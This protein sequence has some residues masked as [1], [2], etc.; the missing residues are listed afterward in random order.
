MTMQMKLIGSFTILIGFMLF[1]AMTGLSRLGATQNRLRTIVDVSS[2]GGLLAAQIQQDMLRLQSQQ[3]A[4]ALADT[5]SA[6]DE[7]HQRL[8]K[9]ERLILDKLAQL[10]SLTP[11]ASKD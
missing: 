2:T 8:V 4:L 10:Q 9:T 1:L 11:E 6:V 3:Q 7:Q 5:A